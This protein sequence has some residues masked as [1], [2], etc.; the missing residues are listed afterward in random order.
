M[1]VDA[2]WPP[3]EP[4]PEGPSFPWATVRWPALTVILLAAV[5][6]APPL[7]AYV[8][9]I[10]ALYCAIESFALLLPSGDGLRQHKQ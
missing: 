10:G 5:H 9:L 1:L 6:L 7:V 8:C 3:P 4:E 2:R